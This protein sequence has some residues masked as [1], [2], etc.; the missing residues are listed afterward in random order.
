MVNL[1]HS[2]NRINVKIMPQ[3][4][5]IM[6]LMVKILIMHRTSLKAPLLTHSNN[7]NKLNK[8]ILQLSPS[9]IN[10]ILTMCRISR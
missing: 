7:R 4:R 5:I 10:R 1:T 8:I 9:L 2:E 6:D 3:H